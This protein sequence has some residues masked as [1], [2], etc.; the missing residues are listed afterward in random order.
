MGAVG[1]SE[2]PG[3]CW[4]GR[5]YCPARPLNVGF[6]QRPFGRLN[7]LLKPSQEEVRLRPSYQELSKIRI[8]RTETHRQLDVRQ[9]LLRTPAGGKC[10]AKGVVGLS[11]A[12]IKL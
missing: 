12:W 9:G 8:L 4:A 11:K 5:Q 3:R 10:H 1:V 7:R 6:T 2:R